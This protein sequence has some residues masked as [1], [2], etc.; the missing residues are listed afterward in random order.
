MNAAA[1]VATRIAV[2]D[3]TEAYHRLLRARCGLGPAQP[4]DGVPVGLGYCGREFR[5]YPSMR[6]A[7]AARFYGALHARWDPARLRDDLATAGLDGRFDIGR[8]KR[9]YQRTIVLAFAMAARPQLLVVEHA[10][11]FD[12]PGALAL[13]EVSVARADRAIVTY[14]GKPHVALGA[15]AA[16]LPA[17]PATLPALDAAWWLA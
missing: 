7:D 12:E 8:M 5:A 6:V 13:L 16:T 10:E 3:A 17:D 4:Y 1:V 2:L 11:E 15:I 9:A 14:A